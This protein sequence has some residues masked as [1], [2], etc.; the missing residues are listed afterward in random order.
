LN[1]ENISL[2]FD[3]HSLPSSSSDL[4]NDYSNFESTPTRPVNI[5]ILETEIETQP[6]TQQDDFQFLLPTWSKK[7]DIIFD[8]PPFTSPEGPT[9]LINDLLM[10]TTTT[11]FKYLFTDEIVDQIVH[12][13]N[14]YAYQKQ[15]KTG[16]AFMRTNI[17]EMKCFIGM[18]LLMGRY[19]E[20]MQL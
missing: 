2:N 11:I 3:F 9:K 12:H 5:N 17:S 19:Q 8:Y 10:C 15:L 1:N 20:A 18:Q 6:A 7:N 14:L 4:N 16:K 13:T